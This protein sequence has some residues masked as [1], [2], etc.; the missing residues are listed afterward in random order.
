MGLR[1]TIKNK[2]KSVA[3]EYINDAAKY[4][5]DNGTHSRKVRAKGSGEFHNYDI[6]DIRED[7]RNKIL[8]APSGANTRGPKMS[9]KHETTE[10]LLAQ[11]KRRGIPAR[12][13]TL[14]NGERE[15]SVDKRSLL[16]DRVAVDL[17]NT[18]VGLRNDSIL[19]HN[20]YNRF[21][22]TSNALDNFTKKK[23]ANAINEVKNTTAS[24]IAMKA[25]AL[26]VH[27]RIETN[28]LFDKNE[29]SALTQSNSIGELE[30]KFGTGSI[31]RLPDE[32]IGYANRIGHQENYNKYTNNLKKLHTDLSNLFKYSYDG[33]GAKERRVV[34]SIKVPGTS[35]RIYT[36]VS[37][38]VYS[39]LDMN[40][41]KPKDRFKLVDMQTKKPATRET[42]ASK[43]N[44]V[45]SE[46]IDNFMNNSQILAENNKTHR[47]SVSDMRNEVA[48]QKTFSKPKEEELKAP[49]FTSIGRS[50]MGNMLELYNE[51]G[52]VVESMSPTAK[53]VRKVM[54]HLGVGDDNS[55]D[56]DVKTW[57]KD[58][59]KQ[60]DKGKRIT[61]NTTSKKK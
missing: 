39:T 44:G 15:I 48:A 36:N 56:D 55:S 20:S 26:D 12:I 10:Y 42:Q 45:T 28:P 27:N 32:V 22:N 19:T 59:S 8:K 58:F 54:K 52:N 7:T 35:K 51:K 31:R 50:S 49:K 9:Q 2:V 34:T 25:G 33:I 61:F 24:K 46:E 6:D 57:F 60:T 14:E 11:L 3:S 47:E 43:T 40:E 23:Q 4:V 41:Y 37:Y 29:T 17:Y 5:P 30:S 21:A 1:E 38:P 13:K 18:R 53:N 16:N